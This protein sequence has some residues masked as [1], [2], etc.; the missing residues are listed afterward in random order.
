MR[1]PNDY[2]G[3][4]NCRYEC[5]QVITDRAV[6]EKTPVYQYFGKWPFYRFYGIQEPASVIFSIGNGLIHFYFFRQI[7]YKCPSAYFLKGF[8]LLYAC[9][10][11][12]AWFWSIIFHSRDM[13]LTER[14][15]YF[16]AVTLVLYSLFFALL[17]VFY[18]RNG[19]VIQ[20]FGVLFVCCFVA[21]VSYLCIVTFDY[22]YNM[23]AN[24]AVG[25]MQLL[26]WVYWFIAQH[27]VEKNRPRLQYA[28]LA[29][30]SVVGVALA[31]CLELFDFPP[32]W[33][34]LDAHSLWHLSTIPLSV[35]WYKF[36]LQ[37]MHYECINVVPFKLLPS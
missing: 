24:V 3:A 10:G 29:V 22:I 36:L 25:F 8:M 21:H 14:M 33:R 9:G 12:N 35:V 27:V 2:L 34:V 17:R 26:V 6:I 1:G 15:D 16:S 19:V 11:M 4:E 20:S 13:K 31:M 5:M 18:I 7:Q 28:H 32:L 37:D 30:I 23:Y